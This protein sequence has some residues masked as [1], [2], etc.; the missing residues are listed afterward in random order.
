MSKRPSFCPDQSCSPLTTLDDTNDRTGTCIGKLSAPTDHGDLKGV[1][2]KRWCI[3]SGSLSQLMVNDDDFEFFILQMGQA[4][5]ADGKPLRFW[6][7]KTLENQ[8]AV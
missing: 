3:M 7:L 5:K 6:A 4:A 1:N 2:D 8:E